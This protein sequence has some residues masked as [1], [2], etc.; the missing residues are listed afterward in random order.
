MRVPASSASACWRGKNRRLA[1]TVEGLRKV[2]A[3]EQ[4]K[5][6]TD[7]AVIGGLDGYLLRFA[8]E[9]GITRSHEISRILQSLPPGG[10]RSL[11]PIQRE[12]V[13]DELLRAAENGPSLTIGGASQV[14]LKALPS[15][16]TEPF[17]VTV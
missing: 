1:D 12:R 5:K 3:L 13:V 11:H 17:T 8:R 2:L 16:E 7:S 6:F 15:L 14:P 9:A 4:K 10:Y